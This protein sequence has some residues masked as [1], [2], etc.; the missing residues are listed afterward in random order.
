MEK[1]KTTPP[2]TPN[3]TPAVYPSYAATYVPQASCSYLLKVNNSR[4]YV[5]KRLNPVSVESVSLY[6]SSMKQT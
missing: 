2:H 6:V 4:L 5:Y 3:V 1:K